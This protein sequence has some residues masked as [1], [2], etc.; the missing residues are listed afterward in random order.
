MHNSLA[1]VVDTDRAEI[2]YLRAAPIMQVRTVLR[3]AINVYLAIRAI[4]TLVK[5]GTVPDS[6][7]VNRF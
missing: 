6:T 5:F 4:L 1:E 3:E 2:P 7:P